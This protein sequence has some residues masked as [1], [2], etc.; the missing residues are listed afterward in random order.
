MLAK[1]WRD[2]SRNISQLLRRLDLSWIVVTQFV[3]VCIT[4][5][6]KSR[7]YKAIFKMFKVG[8]KK[9]VILCNCSKNRTEKR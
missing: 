1:N 8:F 6:G 7:I 9:I 2:S 5:A 4:A 3:L